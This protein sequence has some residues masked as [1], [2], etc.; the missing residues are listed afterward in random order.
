VAR[1]AISAAVA[2]ETARAGQILSLVQDNQGVQVRTARAIVKFLG[3][4]KT[5]AESDLRKIAADTSPRGTEGAVN[6]VGYTL[7]EAERLQ[8]AR[9]IFELN[10]RLFPEAFNTWDSL[11]EIHMMLGHDKKAIRLYEKSLEL[12]PENNN[13]TEMIHRIRGGISDGD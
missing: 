2:E 5:A 12:N 10:T 13:A 7:I 11:A 6:F 3:G 9:D 1:A 4:Q 8:E